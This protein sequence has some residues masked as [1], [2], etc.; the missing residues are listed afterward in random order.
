VQEFVAKAET[1]TVPVEWH[2]IGSLQSNKVKYLAGKASLEETVQAIKRA[3]RRF[4]RHQA[5]WFQPGDPRI[6]WLDAAGDPFETA[7]CLVQ[8]FLAPS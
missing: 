4:V 8:D 3:T 1:V 2:F 7:L 5:N 6:H